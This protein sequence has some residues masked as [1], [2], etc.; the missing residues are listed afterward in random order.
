MPATGPQFPTGEQTGL[1]LVNSA[2]SLFALNYRHQ[3]ILLLRCLSIKNSSSLTLASAYPRSE[4]RYMMAV[5]TIA[6]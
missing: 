3:E 6:F 4:Y 1:V 2:L 5:G